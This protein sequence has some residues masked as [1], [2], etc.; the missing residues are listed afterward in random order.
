MS[1]LEESN[2]KK[3]PIS[4]LGE[5]GL[6]EHITKSFDN[7]NKSTIFGVGDDAAVIKYT[8]D[9]HHLLSTDMLVEGVHFDL[10]YT[11]LKHLGYKAVSVNVSDICAMNGRPTHITVSIAI[12]N[13]FTIES[14]EELY[15]GIKLA[16]ENYNIDLVGGD[17]T[18]S[19]NGLAISIT[20]LGE[21][22]K[23]SITYRRGAKVNDLVVVSGDLGGCLLRLQI[24]KREK[25]IFL[26]NPGVQPD[27]QGND[28]ALQRQ[29]KVEARLKLIEVLKEMDIVPSS[30]IDISD[31][32]TSEILHLSKQSNVGITIYEDKLPIDYTT[33]N[34]AKDLKI[35]PIFCALNGGED[36][37]LLFTISQKHYE[38]LKKDIDF[39]IIGHVTD[40]SEGNN[41]ITNDASSH[42]I[43]AQG[44]D[45]IKKD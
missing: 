18:S 12:S 19:I 37:E 25:E 14:V 35:N 29:L 10:S 32:L 6:I 15:S 36:Y 26:A 39:T 20:I 43:T 28:Y 13:R 31:G 38:K 2:I 40:K 23:N 11:P 41:F 42:P 22:D 21:V 5:F 34:L 1:I 30:M 7:K 33:M 24:L 44:W 9:K 3:T 45:P 17:T 16:C 8:K 4:D 27:L